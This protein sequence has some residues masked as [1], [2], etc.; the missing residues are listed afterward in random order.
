M[1]VILKCGIVATVLT[2][3]AGGVWLTQ[4]RTQAEGRP[5]HYSD[6]V[7]RPGPAAVNTNEMVWIP[8]GTF[9]MG[10][11]SGPADERPL[12]QVTV[13]GIWM[14]KTVVTIEEFEKFTQATGYVTV[15]E[16]KP[17]LKD[18]PGADPAL[19]VPGALVFS[20][21]PGVTSLRDPL[22]WWKYVPG[23]NWRHP[24]G[25]GS[26]IQGR[27]KYPVVEVCWDDAVS[28]AR[29]RGK[30]LP[31]EAEW[32]H[33]ARGGLDRKAFAWGDEKVPNGRWQA[34]IWQGNFPNQNTL[35]DGFKGTAPVGSFAANG[36]GLYDMAGNV[37]EWCADYYA[38]DYYAN[39]PEKSPPGPASSF[40][41]AEP[42][43]V[44]RVLRGGS[45][46]CSDVYCG[47]YRPSARMK[48]MPDTG[49]SHTGFRCVQDAPPP[50]K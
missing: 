35:G 17:D 43:V 21:P 15:A 3:M 28:Y 27:G 31:T 23:A 46:L 50:D 6:A 10:S 7:N 49:L 37:W 39:S 32:E 22:I 45:Y 33:A 11:E 40:D 24:E 44:K 8:P 5:G 47:G 48:S 4:D 42:G 9:W 26:D 41:P 30:R 18:Y 34:N 2:G 36:Y 13:G 14:D 25:P 16:R 19:L 29:W 38:A 20:P 1:T 12:H